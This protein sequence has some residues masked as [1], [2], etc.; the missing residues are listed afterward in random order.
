MKPDSEL[1]PVSTCYFSFG[2]NSEPFLLESGES[3]AEVTLAYE[4]YGELNADRSNA[5]LVF[6]AMTGSQ[7][8][9]GWNETVPNIGGRW[10]E[11]CQIG[12]WEPFIGPGKAFDTDRY[13]VICAN[14]L[15]GCYG[16]TG[17]SS[18]NPKTG[19]P[20]GG[21]FPRI[22]L[23]DI[24][25]SQVR[26]LDHLGISRLL[27]ATGA[28]LGGMLTLLLAS[29][30]PE[31]LQTAIPIASGIDVTP[32]Q[33]ILNFEQ[34]L[35]IETDP[36]FLGGDYY[37][38][39]G[40]LR[41]LALA[42]MIAHKS[43]ISLSALDRRARREVKVEQNHQLA[44]YRLSSPHESYMIHQGEKFTSRFDANTYL[45]ILDA[46][47]TFE[48]TPKNSS[49]S[50]V[51]ILRRCRKIQFLLFTIDSDV[52]FYP[53]QQEHLANELLTANVPFFRLTVHSEK[54]HDAFLLEPE[55]FQ[56]HIAR[57]LEDG[58]KQG[59]VTV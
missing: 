52:C 58:A 49:Q 56:P 14:Y 19:Q 31:R 40:P 24:L 45:R 4:T 48:L 54:G 44:F 7:H 18:I 16:S 27:S 33:R 13:F 8:A 9:A 25:E 23:G 37:P 46:W 29:R 36:D 26:L 43:F 34:I 28:S 38:N 55:L 22:S 5:I 30:Y 53:E 12:W 32:L 47:Q 57:T 2:G 35:A 17:P 1:Q 11:E 21:S 6:H 10:T 20:Y 15:G 3:L 42:R 59:G 51:E 39:P 41:G 50:H